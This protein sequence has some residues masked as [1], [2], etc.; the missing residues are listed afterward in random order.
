MKINS[1]QLTAINIAL[2]MVLCIVLIAIVVEANNQAEAR[3][4]SN[5]EGYILPNKSDFGRAEKNSSNT[6]RSVLVKDGRTST[7]TLCAPPI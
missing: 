5:S 1:R 4:N 2:V 6:Y 7:P 3:N